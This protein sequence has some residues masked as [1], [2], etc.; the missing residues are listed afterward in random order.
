MPGGLLRALNML[1]HR[2][3]Q[4]HIVIKACVDSLFEGPN[5]S[6]NDGPGL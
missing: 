6:R 5:I 4:T 3:G 2:F 1:Q